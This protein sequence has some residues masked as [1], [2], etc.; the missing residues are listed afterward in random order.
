[1]TIKSQIMLAGALATFARMDQLDAMDADLRKSAQ[2]AYAEREQA[3]R[4]EKFASRVR[5]YEKPKNRD[6]EAARRL[7]Q[8]ERIAA[9]KGAVH[10]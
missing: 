3:E 6:R 1:M 7:R 5:A 4:L 2:G 10:D 9:K 8:Q